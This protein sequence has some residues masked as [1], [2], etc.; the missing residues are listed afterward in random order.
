MHTIKGAHL[1]SHGQNGQGSPKSLA[2]KPC[3]R[4]GINMQCTKL[5]NTHWLHPFFSHSPHFTPFY[6]IF[7]HFPPFFLTHSAQYTHT[8]TPR[9]VQ[10]VGSLCM[11][12][13]PHF[14][15]KNLFFPPI[16]SNFSPFFLNSP[17][18]PIHFP[19][20][21]GSGKLV[22]L[23]SFSLVEHARTE[24][25]NRTQWLGCRAGVIV[26]DTH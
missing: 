2:V 20:P 23:Q 26:R 25:N 13:C 10:K 14:L 22:V 6:P 24:S 3:G 11:Q 5:Q 1:I 7:P 19:L 17:I 16:F 18:W 12:S 9:G 4:D 15:T 8:H 21:S